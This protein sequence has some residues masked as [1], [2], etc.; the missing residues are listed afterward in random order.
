[1]K[2]RRPVWSVST[3]TPG[4]PEGRRPRLARGAGPALLRARA[5]H[6]IRAPEGAPSIFQSSRTSR[7]QSGAFLEGGVKPPSPP[8]V[9]PVPGDPTTEKRSLCLRDGSTTLLLDPLEL[10]ERLAAL[11]PPPRRPLVAYHGLLAPRARWRSAIVPLPAGGGR[12]A[13]GGDRPATLALGPAPA[14]GVRG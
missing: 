3:G 14:P 9:V 10:L 2:A 12:R 13:R 1:M 8:P 11:V 7:S 6:I 4:R 5:P